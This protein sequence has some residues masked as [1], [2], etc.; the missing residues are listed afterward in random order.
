MRNIIHKGLF[1]FGES[2]RLELTIFGKVSKPALSSGG[3]TWTFDVDLKSGDRL[4]C[5]DGV[6]WRAVD[7]KR[8]TFAAGRL[9]EPLPTLDG[10]E[11]VFRFSSAG[12]G[13]AAARI[14]MVKRYKKRK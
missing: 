6:N 14:E 9:S 4:Y 5:K 8:K 10:G 11:T 7:A 1:C 13:V 2:A 12:D 3:R